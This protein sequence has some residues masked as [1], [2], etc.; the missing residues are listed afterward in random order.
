MNGSSTIQNSKTESTSLNED[1]G[2]S[3]RS[4]NKIVEEHKERSR[5]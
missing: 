1:M 2:Q 4:L 3:Y 5:N